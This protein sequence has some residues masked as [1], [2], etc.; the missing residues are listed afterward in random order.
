MTNRE[1]IMAE[2]A[3]LDN[4]TFYGVMNDNNVCV[5]MECRQCL[6]CKA[7]HEGICKAIGDDDSCSVSTEDWM[8]MEWQGQPILAEVAT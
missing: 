7:A 4:G 3:T 6:D 8:D 1:R 5:S 2:L